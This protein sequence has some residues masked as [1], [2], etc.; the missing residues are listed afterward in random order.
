MNE[1][2]SDAA[3]NN[4]EKIIYIYLRTAVEKNIGKPAG[5][6][7][8]DKDYTITNTLNAVGTSVTRIT[9]EYLV[10]NLFKC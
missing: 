4:R 7:L 6:L 5:L 10:T 1:V 3:L 8:K 9:F 2:I